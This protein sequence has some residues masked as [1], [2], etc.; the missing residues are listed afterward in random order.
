MFETDHEKCWYFI[1]VNDKSVK[2]IQT[3]I[4]ETDLIIMQT[5]QKLITQTYYGTNVMYGAKDSIQ[6]YMEKKYAYE[7][8]IHIY[9]NY[10]N[11][12]VQNAAS[13]LC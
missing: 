5:L 10:F 7:H 3:C 8:Y 12:L 1:R 2:G 11:F 6:S 9:T 13:Q 4:K